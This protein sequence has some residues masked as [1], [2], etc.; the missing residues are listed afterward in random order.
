LNFEQIKDFNIPVPPLHLQEEFARVA[1]RVEGL[2]GR[3]TEAERQAE[4]LFQ[5]LLAEAFS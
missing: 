4:E 3:M 2:R 1:A 5:S